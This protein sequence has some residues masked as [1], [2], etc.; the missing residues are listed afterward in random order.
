L[1]G[2]PLMAQGGSHATCA[3]AG[4]S[5]SLAVGETPATVSASRAVRHSSR[6]P[7]YQG[8]NGRRAVEEDREAVTA[9]RGDAGAREHGL[10][11]TRAHARGQAVNRRKN[12]TWG[13]K[14]A[15]RTL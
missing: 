2:V 7:V 15:P 1:P 9:E 14:C 10:L 12:E 6:V 11:Y 8:G 4:A 13:M 5:A 3:M